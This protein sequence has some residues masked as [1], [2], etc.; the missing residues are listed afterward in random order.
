MHLVSSNG[1]LRIAALVLTFAVTCDVAFGQVSNGFVEALE[2]GEYRRVSYE[3]FEPEEG[4]ETVDRN[5]PSNVSD[6]FQLGAPQDGSEHDLDATVSSGQS[7]AATPSDSNLVIVSLGRGAIFLCGAYDFNENSSN[8]PPR[9]QRFDLPELKPLRDFEESY[10]EPMTLA[11]GTGSIHNSRSTPEASVLGSGS[12]EISPSQPQSPGAKPVESSSDEKSS[13][14]EP[15]ES[16]GPQIRS[17]S[18]S[19]RESP[20]PD[21]SGRSNAE[22]SPESE[23]VSRSDS[24]S[25]GESQSEPEQ[26]KA[27]ANP[28]TDES[29]SENTPTTTRSRDATDERELELAQEAP[30]LTGRMVPPSKVETDAIIE[31]VNQT[32]V[33]SG[34]P[35]FEKSRTAAPVLSR[36][37]LIRKQRIQSCLAYYLA[38]PESVHVRSPWAVMHAMLPFGVEYEMEANGRRVNAIGWMLFNGKC[39]TQRLFTRRGR[40]F[41]AAEGPGVQGHE[42]QLLAMLAQSY[43]AIDYPISIDRVRYSVKDLVRYEMQNVNAGSELTF[44]LIGLSHYLPSDATWVAADR[45]RW[46]ISKLLNEEMKQPIIGS[47]CGGTHRLMGLTYAILR[48]QQ[49]QLPIDGEFRRAAMFIDDFLGYAWTMQN[50]DGSFSTDWFAGR[51]DKPDRERKVQTTGHILEWII[52]TLPSD[53]VEDPRITR[54]IDFLIQNLLNERRHNWPIGPR[55]HALRALTLYDQKVHGTEPGQQRQEFASVISQMQRTSRR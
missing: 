10:S 2:N 38:H 13:A 53:R 29:E 46:S 28:V 24:T 32:K 45:Q 20:A 23:T 55:G 21:R 17:L 18:S 1:I 33:V 37:A 43:V 36:D 42:G 49:Q 44:Q 19:G 40:M 31:D 26:M 4:S 9:M 30:A 12:S 11:T 35:V 50:V 41:T 39:R 6:V 48:R 7:N 34:Q 22:Q 47:A 15:S 52:Y 3:L 54:A 51:A 25:G 5:S 27:Q 16:Q 8:P 14:A